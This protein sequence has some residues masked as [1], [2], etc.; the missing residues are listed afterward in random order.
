[1]HVMG[2]DGPTP[3]GGVV[4]DRGTFPQPNFVTSYYIYCLNLL[5]KRYEINVNMKGA[6]AE[7]DDWADNPTQG[8][9]EVGVVMHSSTARKRSC[10]ECDEWALS[11]VLFKPASEEY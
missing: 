7:E 9:L 1:M 10:S 4:V 11:L 3:V 8:L 2:S 5:S 6:E